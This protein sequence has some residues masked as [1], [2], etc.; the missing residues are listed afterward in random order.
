[1]KSIA[2]KAENKETDEYW[3]KCEMK[4]ESKGDKTKTKAK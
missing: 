1:M 2:I 4:E 3:H